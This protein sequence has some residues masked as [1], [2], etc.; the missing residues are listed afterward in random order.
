MFTVQGKQYLIKVKEPFIF[1]GIMT[2]TANQYNIAEDAAL[3]LSLVGAPLAVIAL[4]LV[5][6]NFIKVYENGDFTNAFGFFVEV[7]IALF[8][9]ILLFRY[10]RSQQ[11]EATRIINEVSTTTLKLKEITDR[12]EEQ[13]KRRREAEMR[14]IESSLMLLTITLNGVVYVIYKNGFK[15]TE[16]E[17]QM[18]EFVRA[19][20]NESRVTMDRVLQQINEMILLGGGD[21]DADML[22]ALIN[23]HLELK[24]RIRLPSIGNRWANPWSACISFIH[25]FAKTYFPSFATYMRDVFESDTEQYLLPDVRKQLKEG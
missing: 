16:S 11:A 10:S 14:V 23:L 13:R 2:S 12:L 7:G 6:L 21:L 19:N 25:E 20:L 4:T 8:I 24:E 1:H 18:S 5:G 15:E 9:S 22:V 3:I 17:E